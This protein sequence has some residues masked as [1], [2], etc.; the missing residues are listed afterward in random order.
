MPPRPHLPL[1]RIEQRLPRR[2]KPGFGTA[3][4]RDF[5]GHG[6]RIN[7]EIDAAVAAQRARPAIPGIDPELILKVELTGAIDEDA[8]RRAGFTV[9]AQNPDNIFVLFASNLELRS[10]R[11]RLEA[12]QNGPADG[13]AKAPYSQLIG[14]IESAAEV[15]P[16]DRIGP[17]LKSQGLE[18]VAQIDGRKIYVV[19]I[20]LW[21]AGPQ[22]RMIRAQIIAHFLD[23]Q[24]AERIGEP[25]VTRH[26]LILLRA[27]VRGPLLGLVLDRPEVALVDLPPLPDLGDSDPPPI[28]INEL[29][30]RLAPAENAPIIG[31]VDSGVN[32]HPLLENVVIESLGIPANLGTADICGHGTKVAG[33]AS[34]GDLRERVQANSFNAPVRIISARVVNDHG[35]FDD[36]QKLPEQMR[37]AITALAD[38]GC[39]VVNMSLG[40]KDLI[41]YAGG[42]AS[43]WASELDTLARE[44][45]L[46]IVVS[47]GNSASGARAPWGA[48]NDAIL[49]S[50]PGYLTNPENRLIDPAIAANVITVGALA[51]ANGLNDDV[52]DVPQIQHVASINQPCPITRSGPGIAGAIKPEFCEHGGTLVFDGHTDRL[53]KGDH[54]ASA[55]MLTL[56]PEYRR[57]LFT[58]ATGTSYAAPRVAYKAALIAAR[59]P[60]ASANLIR[61][62]LAISA[63]IPSEAAKCI[64]PAMRR[65][66]QPSAAT[67]QCLGYGV[68]DLGH[69]LASDDTRTV[70]LADRQDM[71]LDQVA[72]YA[73]PIPR[74]FQLTAGRRSIRVALAFDP[75]VRHTRI[76]YLSTRMS[77]HLVR[78]LT[79]AQVLDFFRRREDGTSIPDLPGT[80]KCKLEPSST[81]R[82]SSTLQCATFTQARNNDGYGDVFYVAVFTER[83]WAGDDITRQNYALA[84]EL[85]HDTCQTLWQ[86][87]SD[88]NIELTQRLTVMA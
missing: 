9:I 21:D 86:R 60:N 44:R 30:P 80:A 69:A 65:N 36:T 79:D 43:S 88:L 1:H 39:R 20:E 27:R 47:A 64:N 16:D 62:L 12:F 77:F 53:L 72:L 33:I 13:Q 32:D 67:R 4:D 87:C 35:R 26:G 75:P 68:P 54:L 17:H 48:A 61:A 58:S 29:P 18:T 15:S 8:W 81:V 41:P 7:T 70:L 52:N 34:Y 59:Y 82:G 6:R 11:D 50:Y 71:E 76:E 66:E 57:S 5:R 84:V 24:G 56:E 31:I 55:G 83:R 73:V 46:V 25:F 45:D 28:T 40:D 63:D 14:S 42:R 37:N 3:V 22:D 38:K 19:D 49:T 23:G 2:L 85:R 74:D 51:H 10:F 78:G